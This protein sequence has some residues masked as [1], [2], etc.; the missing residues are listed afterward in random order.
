M[1]E[2]SAGEGQRP[3]HALNGD[4]RLGTGLA[5]SG[6]LMWGVAPLFWALVAHIAAA[7]VVA[8]RI[9]WSLALAAIILL[10]RGGAARSLR[11]ALE[12]KTLRTLIVTSLL[13]SANWFLFVWAAMNGRVLESSLGYFIGPLMSVAIGAFILS[14]PLRRA[15]GLAV[16]VAGLGVL[17]LILGLGLFPWV[18]LSLAASFAVYGYLRKGVGIDPLAGLLVESVIALP[19]AVGVLA[20]IGG[21]AP[22]TAFDWVLLALTGPVTLIPLL[23]YNEGI[24]RIRLTTLGFV[25]YVSPSAHFII[26]AFVF[27]EAV[28]PW[29]MAAFALIWAALA[30]F[31]VDS[32][33]AERPLASA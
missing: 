16:G 9:L 21:D 8:H 10:A 1:S 14:E 26:G 24:R 27:E 4:V 23:L 11:P 25:Q 17:V 15:Q 30:V 33:R 20:L 31:T 28:S 13:I 5:F 18:S 6:F 2:G 3:V 29:H 32:L 19:L 22:Y 12:P 7:E